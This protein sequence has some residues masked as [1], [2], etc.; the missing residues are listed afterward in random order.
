MTRARRRWKSQTPPERASAEQRVAKRWPR[1]CS[2]NVRFPLFPA[3]SDSLATRHRAAQPAAH[4]RIRPRAVTPLEP[5]T[6]SRL[7]RSGHDVAVAAGGVVRQRWVGQDRR[8]VSVTRD[9]DRAARPG[10][11]RSGQP[12]ELAVF[13]GQHGDPALGEVGV[14]GV[15]LGRLRA[16]SRG[17]KIC[18]VAPGQVGDALL[19]AGRGVELFA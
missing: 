16:G 2:A 12:A 10:V 17:R 1:E 7:V 8:C 5:S 11:P 9:I 13:A 6:W 18:G 15:V 19:V 3:F 4:D 14:R